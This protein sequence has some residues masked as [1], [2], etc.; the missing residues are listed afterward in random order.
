MR[1]HRA[2]S[3]NALL[4]ISK[5]PRLDR[6]FIQFLTCSPKGPRCVED[7]RHSDVRSGAVL[8]GFAQA[9]YPVHVLLASRIYSEIFVVVQ[10]MLLI[11]LQMPVRIAYSMVPLAVSGDENAP[12]N[13]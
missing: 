3:R 11:P 6:V 5:S 4:A 8:A 1:W 13:V 9:T 7:C 2:Y 10:P 12:V